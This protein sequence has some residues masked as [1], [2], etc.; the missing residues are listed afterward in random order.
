MGEFVRG[1]EQFKGKLQQILD[2]AKKLDGENR[3]P[4]AE[5]FSADFMRQHTRVGSFE[6]LMEAGGFGGMDFA[7]IPAEAWEATVRAH[8]S[9]ASWMEMQQTAAATWARDRLLE[10][11]P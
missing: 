6:Q 9:F 11:S 1:L 10:G 8:T 3:I 7:A 4:L 2:N 5:A